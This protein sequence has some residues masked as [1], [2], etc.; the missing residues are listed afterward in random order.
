MIGFTF[1]ADDRLSLSG[2]KIGPVGYPLVLLHGGGPD[3]GMFV[4]LAQKLAKTHSILL[5]DVRGYGRSICTDPMRHTWDQYVR[6]VIV[7]LDH[8][9]IDS[10]IVG[11][12][13]LGAT[14][15]LRTALAYPSRVKALVLISVEDIE[16]DVA[17]QAEIAFMDAF[18]SRV[19]THGIEAGWSPI[20][21][22]L[23]PLIGELVREA[24]P[25]SD[26]QSIAAAA[27]IGHDRSFGSID[28]LGVITCPTLIIPGMDERHPAELAVKL[29]DVLPQGH[30]AD[31]AVTPDVRTGQGLAE[32]FAPAIIEFLDELQAGTL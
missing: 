23:A 8:F 18:A 25:R 29:A 28:E 9:N 24:I 30:L 10:A 19:R 17:K 21:P 11:G 4:P 20:L 6:D 13:G 12:A 26:P 32:A 1:P 14:I 2:V 22:T 15:S 31:V 7:L 27:A 3:H 16:D 5:P